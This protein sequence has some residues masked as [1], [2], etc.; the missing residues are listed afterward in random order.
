LR[1]T[2]TLKTLRIKLQVRKPTSR[3]VVEYKNTRRKGPSSPN[4]IWGDMDLSSVAKEIQN[5]AVPVPGLQVGAE[6]HDVFAVASS[7]SSVPYDTSEVTAEMAQEGSLTEEEDG[8]VADIDVGTAEAQLAEPEEPKKRRGRRK[9]LSSDATVE[10]RPASRTAKPRRKP[11]R[12]RASGRGKEDTA[13]SPAAPE[14][15]EAQDP[16]V[17]VTDASAPVDKL[18]DLLQLEQ[19]NLRL[20]KLLAEKLREENVTLRKRLGLD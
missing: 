15:Q 5:E 12:P 9:K 17:A 8:V 18:E 7:S 6:R 1:Y 3:F 19:E 16:L 11:G 14:H 4:S 20:R 13:Q 10:D 2:P